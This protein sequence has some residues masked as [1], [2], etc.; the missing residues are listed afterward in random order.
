[1]SLRNKILA[2]AALTLLVLYSLTAMISVRIVLASYRQLEEEEAI[3]DAQRVQAVL[4]DKVDRLDRIVADWAAW[5]DTRDFVL[6]QYDAF[7]TENMT[8]ITFYDNLQVNLMAFATAAGEIA[9]VEFYDLEAREQVPVPE[10]VIAQLESDLLLGHDDVTD[11][12][13]GIILLPEGP[14]FVASRPITNSLQT[15][16]ING[17]LVM[18]HYV[19]EP[20]LA[21]LSDQ[22]QS[23]LTLY[24]YGDPNM[25]A[26]F[27]VEYSEYVASEGEVVNHARPLNDDVVSAYVPQDDLYGNPAFLLRVDI[28]RELY[29]RGRD[30]RRF[31]LTAT[32]IAGASF[33]IMVLL[34]LQSLVLGRLSRLTTNVV[35]IGR[36]RDFEGRVPVDGGDELALVARSINGMLDVFE[37]A[38]VELKQ[39]ENRYRNVVEDMDEFICRFTPDGAVTFA[40]Q[41]YCEHLGKDCDEIQ[42]SHLLTRR[43]S[44]GNAGHPVPLLRQASP[45]ETYVQ[46]TLASDGAL[47][48]IEWKNHALVDEQG[49]VVEFQSIGRDITEQKLAEEQ[50]LKLAMERERANI[51]LAFINDA[52]HELRTPLAVITSNLFLLERV[53]DREKQRT[54]IARVKAEAEYL[55][56]LVNAMLSMTQ[57]DKVSR[58]DFETVDL[59]QVIGLL[60][61]QVKPLLDEH[62]LTLKQELSPVLPRSNGDARR[63]G[64]ALLQIVKNAVQYTEPGGAVT[65]RSAISG[66]RVI[67]EVIDTGSGIPADEIPQIFERFYRVDKAR[68]T[69]GAGLGL[70]IAKKI[71][72]LHEGSIEVES[73]PGAGSTFR[74]MLACDSEVP[75]VQESPGLT[76]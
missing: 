6:G 68:T 8:D 7:V 39:S 30:T 44:E 10:S 76:A 3:R 34:L 18:G 55:V 75:P 22:M 23:E 61:Q 53:D 27:A 73:E 59:N 51:L 17:T 42:T 24:A 62:E 13:T 5:D 45:G 43:L 50:R 46:Q 48:W 12:V 52:S 40:N 56:D 58:L 66:D 65:L 47:C 20:M 71:I 49:M 14:M 11:S 54:W 70:S 57:L 67:V 60:A 35:R 41:A 32:G 74:V 31:L 29:Q 69:R 38:Q 37:Q 64:E 33:G 72:D 25:P 4:M 28:P 15:P 21:K 19:D 26:D 2:I 16:P 36:S 9:Y 63:L 1:M